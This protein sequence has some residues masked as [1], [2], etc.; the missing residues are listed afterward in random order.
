MK[1]TVSGLRAALKQKS[2]CKRWKYQPTELT[3]HSP[4]L[5]SMGTVLWLLLPESV[6]VPSAYTISVYAPSLVAGCSSLV[7][8]AKEASLTGLRHCLRVVVV[9]RGA[10]LLHVGG[11][12][13]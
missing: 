12:R 11:G 5:R 3:P 9:P 6:I 7:K 8:P 1:C 13:R 2:S 10:V 4:F